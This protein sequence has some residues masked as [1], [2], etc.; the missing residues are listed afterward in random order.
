VLFYSGKTS[1]ADGEAAL[2]DALYMEKEVSK[3]IKKLIDVCDSDT[4]SDY[5]AA[6]WLTGTWLEEQLGGQRKLAGMINN[7]NTFKREHEALADW[8]F[9]QQLLKA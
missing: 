4:S 1:W 9:S 6:D 8:M 7:L 5:H 2:R 3:S